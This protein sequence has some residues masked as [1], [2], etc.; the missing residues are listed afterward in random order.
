MSGC[1]SFNMFMYIWH[2]LRSYH[3]YI[4][5]FLVIDLPGSQNESSGARAIQGPVQE[6]SRRSEN[7]EGQGKKSYFFVLVVSESHLPFPYQALS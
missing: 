3:F 7:F 6:K 1:H 4:I 2:D 5:M